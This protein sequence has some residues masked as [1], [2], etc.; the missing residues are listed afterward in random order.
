MSYLSR[1]CQRLSSGILA[2]LSV[3]LLLRR[4]PPHR[5]FLL[6]C[7]AFLIGN[8]LTAVAPVKTTY[9]AVIFPSTIVVIFGPGLS[10]PFQMRSIVD[11]SDLSYAAGQFLISTAVKHE[12]QSIAG[13]MVAMVVNYS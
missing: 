12:H 10:F 4:L 3:P 13:A 9:W 2:A 5:I 6:S 8:I 7:I 1:R 11:A